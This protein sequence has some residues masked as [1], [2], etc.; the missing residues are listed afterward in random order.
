MAGMQAL[1]GKEH[2]I[3]DKITKLAKTA[4]SRDK[5]IRESLGLLRTLVAF[6]SAVLFDVNPATLEFTGAF[7]DNLDRDF[8][9]MYFQKFHKKEDG[10][11]GLR[12]FLKNGYVSKRGSDLVAL[13]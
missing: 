3:T 12:E 5:L 7:L 9:S 4:P 13:K 2:S 1:T 8:L 11:L 10:V 6:D